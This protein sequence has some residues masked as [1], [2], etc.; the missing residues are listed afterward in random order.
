MYDRVLP[1]FLPPSSCANG[2]AA[3]SDL[4]ADGSAVPQANADAMWAGGKAPEGAGRSCAMPSNDPGLYNG[5]CFCKDSHDASWDNCTSPLTIPTQI[6]LQM[7]GP[8]AVVASFV[9]FEDMAAQYTPEVQYST[10][11]SFPAATAQLATGLCHHFTQAGAVNKTYAMH[12][13]KLE[14]LAE[15]TEYFYRVRS[16]ARADWTPG[17]HF[18]SL[19]STGPTKYAVFGE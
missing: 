14:G 13:V 11:A 12:F 5:W 18:T 15:R 1:L 6:N 3:W 2:C 4:A 10:D 17:G 7:A 8:T 19:Y 16:S 9:T